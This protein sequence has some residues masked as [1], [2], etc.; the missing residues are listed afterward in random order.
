MILTILRGLLQRNNK[1]YITLSHDNMKAMQ[2]KENAS[3]CQKLQFK[4]DNFENIM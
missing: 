1:E 4:L 2:D 3:K